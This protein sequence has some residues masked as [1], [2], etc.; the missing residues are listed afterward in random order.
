MALSLVFPFSMLKLP[1][2]KTWGSR[3]LFFLWTLWSLSGRPFLATACNRNWAVFLFNITFTLLSI[4]PLVEIRQI[5]F[6]NL[7]ET[8]VLACEMFPSGFRPWFKNIAFFSKVLLLLFLLVW[9]DKSAEA[10]REDFISVKFRLSSKSPVTFLPAVALRSV[11]ACVTFG[12]KELYTADG[13]PET[14]HSTWK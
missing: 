3:G 11:V 7:A 9:T 10:I 14:A 6:K 4:F 13:K 12:K 2:S 5:S 8:T 1:N